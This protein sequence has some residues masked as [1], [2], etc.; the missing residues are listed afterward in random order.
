MIKSSRSAKPQKPSNS[1][2]NTNSQTK[3]I[4]A[5]VEFNKKNANHQ[6]RK[7]PKQSNSTIVCFR[8]NN[9]M[10]FLTTIFAT[11]YTM[12]IFIYINTV[13]YPGVF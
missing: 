13:G 3:E 9:K 5:I 10:L 11:F 4:I 7:S 6:I 12:Y 1:R 2:K 8:Q